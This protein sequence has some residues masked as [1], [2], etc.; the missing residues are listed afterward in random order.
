MGVLNA[1]VMSS[2]DIHCVQYELLK[3]PLIGMEINVISI[4]IFLNYFFVF[5]EMFLHLKWRHY[6][7]FFLLLLFIYS[8]FVLSFSM[9]AYWMSK[10][11]N[12]TNSTGTG[13]SLTE[14]QVILGVTIGCALVC[15]SGAF[16]FVHALIQVI[17]K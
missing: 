11:V 6:R 17:I 1:I 12:L 14:D 3:H 16:L 9:V 15:F 5:K 13:F 8:V 2:S 10:A 4:I 7:K